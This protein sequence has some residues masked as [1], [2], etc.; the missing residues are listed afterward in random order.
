[1]ISNKINPLLIKCVPVSSCEFHLS[2]VAN[3]L[4]EERESLVKATLWGVG[5]QGEEVRG[6]QSHLEGRHSTLTL[7][8]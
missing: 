4:L 3:V 1:M 8:G 7:K 2:D 5:R 6:V